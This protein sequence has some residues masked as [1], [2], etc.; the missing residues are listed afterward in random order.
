MAGEVIAMHATDPTLTVAVMPSTPA[1]S[2]IAELE[3]AGIDVVKVSA[4]TF[5]AACG[6]FYDAVIGTEGTETHPAVAPKVR[7]REGPANSP[8]VRAALAVAGRRS[9]GTG[10]VWS[11]PREV[12]LT[13]LVAVTIAYGLLPAAVPPDLVYAGSYIDLEDY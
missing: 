12:D 2:I 7:H 11:S 10:W 3:A 13:A 4:G 8:D 9:V 6:A 5:A 1:G